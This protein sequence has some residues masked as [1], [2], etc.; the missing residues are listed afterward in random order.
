V[1]TKDKLI[2]LP[3]P[4]DGFQAT[5]VRPALCLTDPIGPFRHVI[6]AFISS[7]LPDVLLASDMLIARNH[8]AFSATGLKVDS[9]LKLHRLLTVPDSLFQ[10]ELG[11]LPPTLCNTVSDKLRTLFQL[12]T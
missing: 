6:V 3:F 12:Q 9:V 4:F 11:M 2:L 5:K 10:R 1:T 8:P 7:R